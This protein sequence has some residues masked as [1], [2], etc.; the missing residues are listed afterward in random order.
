MY[1][2]FLYNEPTYNDAGG[3]AFTITLTE[4]VT[5]SDMEAFYD[6]AVKTETIT[7]SDL[8]TMFAAIAKAESI[9]LSDAFMTQQFAQFS[10]TLTLSD[11][12]ALVT[13][14]VRTYTD[15]MTLTDTIEKTVMKMLDVETV[16]VSDTYVLVV[17]KNLDEAIF[18][19]PDVIATISGKGCSERLRMND[20][21]SIHQNPQSDNWGD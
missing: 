8:R 1:N 13:N 9:S 15:S 16:T 5:S 17:G 7:M 6:Q 21:L 3:T 4:T 20:W 10:E 19:S 11:F 18:L 2:Q 12:L 14:Y